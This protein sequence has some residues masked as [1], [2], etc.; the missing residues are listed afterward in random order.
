MW[1][2]TYGLIRE[3]RKGC[4]AHHGFRENLLEESDPNWAMKDELA[5]AGINEKGCSVQKK[6]SNSLSLHSNSRA[7]SEW[8]T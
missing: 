4:L 6:R 7:A 1:Q 2:R 8:S 5:S 3:Y